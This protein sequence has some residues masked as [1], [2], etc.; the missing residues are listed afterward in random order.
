MIYLDPYQTTIGSLT[1]NSKLKQALLKNYISGEMSGINYTRK[2]DI[3]STNKITPVFITGL[4]EEE[5]DLPGFDLPILVEY[6]GKPFDLLFI[7]VR[8]FIRSK[9]SNHDRDEILRNISDPM[10][11]QFKRNIAVLIME[12]MSSEED[13]PYFATE[14][15][16]GLV[17]ARWI[18]RNLTNSFHLDMIEKNAIEVACMQFYLNI[19]NRENEDSSGMKNMTANKLAKVLNILPSFAS[20]I[21]NRDDYVFPAVELNELV[22]NIKVASNSRKLDKLTPATLSI[23]VG[24]G[25]FGHNLQKIIAMGLESV[26]VWI[27]LVLRFSDNM[28]KRFPLGELIKIT[29][30]RNLKDVPKKINMLVDQRILKKS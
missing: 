15:G 8:G 12:G 19:S 28:Y 27:A 26:P 6:K 11:Y 25:V 5:H 7:D 21:F 20:Q 4:F 24:N 9:V 18:S 17:Y 23:M 1:D 13:R 2:L 10:E 30:N 29:L 16:C 22:Q 14:L 3:V